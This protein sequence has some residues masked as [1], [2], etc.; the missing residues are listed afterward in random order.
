VVKFNL[1]NHKRFGNME[2]QLMCQ[3]TN[4]HAKNSLIIIKV[5]K[6]A[7]LFLDPNMIN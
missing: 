3:D 5:L 6:A 7:G 1:K 2:L 4:V